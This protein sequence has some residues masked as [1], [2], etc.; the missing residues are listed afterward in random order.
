MGSLPHTILSKQN[1]VLQ[2][3]GTHAL[4]PELRHPLMIDEF[5]HAMQGYHARH[6]SSGETEDATVQQEYILRTQRYSA[7]ICERLCKEYGTND[8]RSSIKNSQSPEYMVHKEHLT[9]MIEIRRYVTG[10]KRR[11]RERSPE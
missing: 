5:Q 8:K 10:A 7:N 3:P 6:P 4:R 9:S 1:I 11:W 2:T